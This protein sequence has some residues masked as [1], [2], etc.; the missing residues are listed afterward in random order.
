MRVK[1]VSASGAAQYY[2]VNTA[3][4]YQSA[5][6]KR[7][8]VGLGNEAAAKRV[9]IRWPAGAVQIFENVKAGVILAAKEPAQLPR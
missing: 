9:E 1:V 7:L 3:A 8:I 4:G 5:S 2:T 6:D